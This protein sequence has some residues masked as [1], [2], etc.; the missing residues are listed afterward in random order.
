MHNPVHER[1]F[2]RRICIAA[3]DLEPVGSA[4]ARTLKHPTTTTLPA[5]SGLVAA[6]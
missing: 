3:S 6:A 1:A 2:T 5:P 4:R